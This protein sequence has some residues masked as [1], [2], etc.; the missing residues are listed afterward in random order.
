MRYKIEV[1]GKGGECYVHLLNEEQREKFIDSDVE[2]DEM[3]AE[4]IAEVL[5][6]NDVFSDSQDTFLGPYNED[7]CLYIKVTTDSDVLVWESTDETKFDTEYEYKFVDDKSL[8]VVDYVK[9]HFFSFNIELDEEFDSNK[10]TLIATEI[11]ERVDIITGLYYGEV[12]LNN[13]KDYDGDYWSKGLT[14]YVN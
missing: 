7:F 6:K 3:S 2:N 12:N 8:L 5:E 13:F 14:Y 1:Y 4:D 9:G 10:L 11:G